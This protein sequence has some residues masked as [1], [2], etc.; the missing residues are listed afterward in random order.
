MIKKI[1]YGR[2]N[3]NRNDIEAVKSVL[4][5]DFITQGPKV[6]E[7]EIA[8][9]NYVG[10]LYAVA[11]NSGTSALHAACA[12]AGIKLGDEVIVPTLSFVASANCVVYCGGKPVLV[13]VYDDTLT[14]NVEE[15]EKKITKKTKAIIAV[16]FAGHPADWGKLKTLS[17]KY[18]LT[19]IDDAAHS[20][21]SKYN[22]RKIGSIADLT[23]FSFHPVK[24]ITTGEGGM[25]TTNNKNYYASLLKFRN[26]GMVKNEETVKKH[27]EWFYEVESLGFNFRLTDIQAS[28]GLTQLKR[29]NTF[30]KSRRKIWKKYNKSLGKIKGVRLPIEK[31][32]FCAWHLYTIRIDAKVAGISRKGLFDYLQSNGVGVQV[33]YIPIHL[34]NFYKETFGYKEGDFP[35]AEKYYHEAISLPLFTKLTD[36]EVN[37]VLKSFKNVIKKY[38]K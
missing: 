24:T 3:I 26:H 35:V 38:Q 33:H 13:D 7:F 36:K 14:I 9:C 23:A 20:I 25:V 27:G 4:T 1:P 37:T 21:G 8:I 2:Q 29:I 18:G 6:L 22:N 30:I 28:L 5:D 19:L 11:V 32:G 10:A 12:V 34:H 17:K 31:F 15:V 16:D